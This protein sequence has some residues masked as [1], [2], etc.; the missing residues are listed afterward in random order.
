MVE[1]D[2]NNFR[3]LVESD[4]NNIAMLESD[5]KKKGE[6]IT[7]LCSQVS[8]TKKIVEGIAEKKEYKATLALFGAE[9]LLL[10]D[11]SV[12]KDPKDGGSILFKW[13]VQ[14]FSDLKEGI[15]SA[16]DNEADLTSESLLALLERQGC[17]VYKRLGSKE[18]VYPSFAESRTDAGKV[19]AVKKA[20]VQRFWEVSGCEAVRVISSPRLTEVSIVTVSFLRLCWRTDC[21]CIAV[22]AADWRRCCCYCWWLGG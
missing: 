5:L 20:F 11:P 4:A 18:F 19:Q 6:T 3:N 8:A 15:Y 9:P 17:E 14:E 21:D 16:F 22:C 7:S 2:A 12:A 1:S 13:L 10:P